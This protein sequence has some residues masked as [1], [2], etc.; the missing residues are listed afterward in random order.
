ML[1][2]EAQ[3]EV[4]D[5]FLNG[6]VGTAVSGGIWLP[7]AALGTWGST[8]Q[9]ILA[10]AMGGAFIFPITQLI[11]RLS[12]RR[13]SL[14]PENPLG[15]LAMQ[16]AFTIPLALPVIG[17][18]TLKNLNWFYPAFAVIVGAHYLPFMFLYG[19]WHYA[20][21]AALLI[22]GGV[23][24]GLTRGDAFTL[25]GWLTGLVLVLSAIWLAGSGKAK[26]LAHHA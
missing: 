3:R 11:L 9:A 10:L 2:A 23:A 17:A 26:P 14:R 19:M 20:V 21:V 25:G 8:H 5:V 16:V 15:Q 13:A 7:S 4:R 1:I 18:A 24:V 6:A 22:G 12:G